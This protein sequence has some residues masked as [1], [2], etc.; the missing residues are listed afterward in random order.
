M[1][2]NTTTSL[3]SFDQREAQSAAALLKVHGQHD[4]RAGGLCGRVQHRYGRKNHAAQHSETLFNLCTAHRKQ[5]ATAL[6]SSPLACLHGAVR[7]STEFLV[8]GGGLATQ[9]TPPSMCSALHAE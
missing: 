2:P 3:R 1:P 7:M 9:A 5:A 4:I 8:N 6:H